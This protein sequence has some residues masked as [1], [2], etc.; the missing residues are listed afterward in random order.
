MALKEENIAHNEV[1]IKELESIQDRLQE[2]TTKTFYGE[3]R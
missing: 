2:L 3:N 1:K